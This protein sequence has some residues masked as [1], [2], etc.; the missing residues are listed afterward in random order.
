MNLGKNPAKKTREDA[1]DIPVDAPPVIPDEA[2][3][4]EYEEVPSRQAKR[5]QRQSATATAPTAQAIPERRTDQSADGGAAESDAMDVH[6]TGAAAATVA[7]DDDWL[8][9]RTNRLLDL[10]GADELDAEK[11]EPAPAAAQAPKPQPTSE[12]ED[13]D[14]PENVV[15]DD[16]ATHSPEA[17]E[18]GKES[19]LDS[20]RKTRRI[21]VRNLPYTA[22][23]DELRKYFTQFGELE[24][25][26][27]RPAFYFYFYFPSR[28]HCDE[29]L[30]GTSD[31]KGILMRCQG[32]YFS[33]CF[34]F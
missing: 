1:D 24:E 13:D 6:S 29:P 14:A 12:R 28:M 16:Q 22:T 27:P 30:I 17:K 18:G 7:D 2:S 20:V 23:E 32:Q 8:R 33:R 5:L 9:Q 4:D 26:S 34:V 10:V 21:F 25:V 15:S 3:D 11:P 31:A 19:P